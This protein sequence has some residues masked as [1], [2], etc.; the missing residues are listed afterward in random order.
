MRRFRF[1]LQPVLKM[2]EYVEQQRK[3]ELGKVAGECAM[4]REGIGARDTE[5]HRRLSTIPAEGRDDIVYR[6][7][8]ETYT[9]RL[10]YEADSLGRQLESRE[11]DRRA[12]AERFAEAKQEA[13]VLRKL[14]DH[15]AEA[16]RAEQLHAEQLVLDEVARNT[17]LRNEVSDGRT[18]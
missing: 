13:D 8:L 18:V 6:K 16:H 17:Y 10:K 2:R 9:N 11:A 15:R 4:L 14:R 3:L 7:I 1:R 5:R 12:A